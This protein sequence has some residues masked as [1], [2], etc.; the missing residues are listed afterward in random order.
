MQ[1]TGMQRLTVSGCPTA[2][3]PQGTQPLLPPISNVLCFL[4]LLLLL[5]APGLGATALEKH[6]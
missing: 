1:S 4:L 3:A 2:A 6:Q 5:K